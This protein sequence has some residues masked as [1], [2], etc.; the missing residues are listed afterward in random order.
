[1]GDVDV[2]LPTFVHVVIV[3]YEFGNFGVPTHIQYTQLHR[4]ISPTQKFETKIWTFG[5]LLIHSNL[6]NIL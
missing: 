5:Q 2:S 1:M 6:R 4:S 3:D